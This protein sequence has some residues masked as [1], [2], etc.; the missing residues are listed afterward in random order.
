[1]KKLLVVAAAALACAFACLGA[2]IRVGTYNI[3]TSSGDKGTPNAW[4]ER[5]D[6]LCEFVKKLDLDVV[7]FQEVRYNQD[8]FLREKF[9]DYEFVGERT[10]P[11]DKR[12]CSVPVVFRKDR[13]E[14]EKSGTFWLSETPDVK[15][16][17]SWDSAEPRVCSYAVLK[18]RRSGRRFCFANTHMDHRGAVAREKGALLIVE[19][20]KEFGSGAPIVFVGD[21]NSNEAEPAARS[22]LRI[23]DNAL[24]LSEKAPEGGWRTHNGWKWRDEEVSAAE[25]LTMSVRARNSFSGSPDGNRRGRDKFFERCGGT[26]IDFIYVTHGM[27]V[28]DYATRNDARPC[29]GLYPSDHF[30]IVA[31]I[32][33]PDDASLAEAASPKPADLRIA[34]NY[35]TLGYTMAGWGEKEWDK[36][37]DRIAARGYNVALVTAG[38][39]KVWQLVLRDFG[40]SEEGIRSYI[41]DEWAQPWWSMG[42][43]GGE[44]GPLD[45]ATVEADAALGRRIVARMAEK[46]IKPLLQGFTGLFPIAAPQLEHFKG[47]TFIPQGRWAGYSRP[48]LLLP[49]DPAFAPAAATWY[50]RLREVYGID[51]I[52]YLAGDLFHEG[53]NTNGADVPKCIAAVQSAQQASCPGAIWFVQSWRENPTPAVCAGLDPRFSLIE[54]LCGD[55]GNGY[56]RDSGWGRIPWVWCEVGNFGGNHG[57]YG[58][59]RSYSRIGRAAKGLAANQFRGWG[60]LSEGY[61]T[62]PVCQDLFDDMIRKPV[63]YEMSEEELDAWLRAWTAKRYGKYND[64]CLDEAWRLLKDSVY[65]CPRAQHGAVKNPMTLSPGW[66]LGA[67]YKAVAAF[68]DAKSDFY[69]NPAHVEEAAGIFAEVAAKVAEKRPS[70]KGDPELSAFAFDFA[71]VVRQVLADRASALVPKLRGETAARDSFLALIDAEDAL[72]ACV[73]EFRLDTYESEAAAKAGARGPVAFRRMIT[74]WRN[75]GSRQ[76]N[77]TDYACRDYAGL[78]GTYYRSRWEAF[79]RHA[80]AAKDGNPG[81]E[82]REEMYKLENDFVKNGRPAP[83][84]PANDF[85]ALVERAREALGKAGTSSF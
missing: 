39:P 7:G 75:P 21:H 42:N 49:T 23:L 78:L 79:F 64:P 51:E 61:F 24:Y 84:M 55:M 28:V 3:R 68:Q 72:L 1:M 31:T 20:M 82:Y 11:G 57:L 18:D 4:A 71:N 62:N 46:G 44:G 50:R 43:L 32:E 2:P 48:T 85:A 58:N 52:P 65:N 80:G 66:N 26:R 40:M 63:G 59:L 53:G 27:R 36:E 73:P 33:V 76:R 17:K 30:P 12:M 37:I 41:P 74:T 19:R 22:L 6:D 15:G 9:P 8:E 77:L 67:A 45:D 29:G 83:A 56:K 60:S 25:A 13:F 38:L 69:W 5:K 81:K 35:C 70:A 34:Y 14:C 16:S 10:V 47:A 54:G